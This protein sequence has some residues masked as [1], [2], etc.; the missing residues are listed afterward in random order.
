M[1]FGFSLDETV[2]ESLGLIDITQSLHNVIHLIFS[3]LRLFIDCKN[4]FFLLVSRCKL[5]YEFTGWVCEPN[6][7]IL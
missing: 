5:N 2:H 4:N 6:Y 7:Q 3:G 1:G